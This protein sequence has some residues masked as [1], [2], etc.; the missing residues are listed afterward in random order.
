MALTLE[1]PLGAN[2]KR[3]MRPDLCATRV[4]SG[5]RVWG[6]V[7]VVSPLRTVVLARVVAD[8]R[9]VVAG[10]WREG[11]K[12]TKYGSRPPPADPP[13][14]FTPLVWEAYVRVGPATPEFL[15]AAVGGPTGGQAHA[16]L[17]RQVG[18]A[19][20]RANARAALTG[21]RLCTPAGVRAWPM[22][23]DSIAGLWPLTVSPELVGWGE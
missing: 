14:T 18:V 1:L 9:A 11:K 8:S 6:D 21:V 3:S 17:L 2:R 19:L 13:S 15:A 7:S 10:V 4:G 20:W 12:L 22:A 5:V 16:T 23:R